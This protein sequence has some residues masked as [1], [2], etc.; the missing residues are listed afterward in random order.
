MARIAL[1]DDHRMFADGF[2]VVIGQRRS[3]SRVEVFDEPVAFLQTLAAGTEYDLIV[4]DLVMQKM[5]GLALLAAIRERRPKA[6]VLMLSGTGAEA[7]VVKMQQLGAAGFVHKSDDTD[8]L[9]QAV[10]AIL[11]GGTSFPATGPS[12]VFD[13][14]SDTFAGDPD[15]SRLPEL[16]PRQ[17]EVLGLMGRGETNKGI[18]NALNISE[19]TVKSHMRAIFDALGARTRTACVRK[20]QMLGLI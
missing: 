2:S 8:V 11:E 10:D 14:G 15:A 1:I 19:N 6:R 7:P 17:L 18:A 13:D 3:E 20:A 16:G 5:N 4:V 9:I 12:S